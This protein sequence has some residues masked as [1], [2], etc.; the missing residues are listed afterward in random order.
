MFIKIKK[1]R[2]PFFCRCNFTEII[3][4]IFKNNEGNKE[5]FYADS[6]NNLLFDYYY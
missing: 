6:L 4:N 1:N 2:M 3:K 5:H